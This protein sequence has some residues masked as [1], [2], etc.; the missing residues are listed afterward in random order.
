MLVIKDV[1]MLKMMKKT[2]VMVFV[3]VRQIV[4]GILNITVWKTV[5]VIRTVE[6]ENV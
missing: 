3:H 4:V 1:T 6:R 2:A 5:F